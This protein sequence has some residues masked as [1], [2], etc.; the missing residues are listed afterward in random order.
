MSERARGTG[1]G[2]GDESGGVWRVGSDGEWKGRSRGVVARTLSKQI[3]CAIA[4]GRW[5]GLGLG[6]FEVGGHWRGREGCGW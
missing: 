3:G 5:L 4:V 6:G 1:A 2:G